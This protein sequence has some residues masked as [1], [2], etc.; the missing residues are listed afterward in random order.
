MLDL[1]NKYSPLIAKLPN[2]LKYSKTDLLTEKFLIEETGEIKMYYAPFDHINKNAKVILIGI[3]PGWTQME[4]AIREARQGLVRQ[5]PPESILERA[6]FAASFAG[7]MRTN[8]I[9]MLD[10]LDLNKIM[11][12]DSTETLFNMQKH[13]LHP[14]SV[15]RYPVFV[16]GENYAGH[17]PKLVKTPMFIRISHRYL[18]E[19]L[20]TAKNALIIPLGKCVESV[21]K[22]LIYKNHLSAEKCLFDFPHPSPANGWRI[23][24]FEEKK[25]VLKMK[26]RKWFK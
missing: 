25:C 20:L 1:F 26:I 15:L 9:T 8:L 18:P 11:G 21:L 7:A 24:Q 2:L 12:I 14:T 19:E 5:L 6:K 13:L 10:E 3:T 22:S 17:M 16:S 4:I 23:R